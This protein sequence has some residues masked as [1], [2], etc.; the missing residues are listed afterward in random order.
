MRVT[1]RVK[2]AHVLIHTSVGL[3]FSCIL[4]SVYKGCL[5]AWCSSL[6]LEA[7]VSCEE[8]LSQGSWSLV[9]FSPSDVHDVCQIQEA[10]TSL[11]QSLADRRSI[12]IDLHKSWVKLHYHFM[13]LA[14][15]YG[16]L[17]TQ[18]KCTI[19][20]VQEQTQMTVHQFH[21]YEVSSWRQA[22]VVEKDATSWCGLQFK[23][24]SAPYNTSY[25]YMIGQ[26]DIWHAEN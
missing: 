1:H 14:I 15:R 24:P 3:S 16:P 23:L 18:L 10:A 20:L 6:Y 26:R 22:R 12:Y 8:S 13:P 4:V 17:A 2:V 9:E 5:G 25:Y 7:G 11:W 21:A 19:T